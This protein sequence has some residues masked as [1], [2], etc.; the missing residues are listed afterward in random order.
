MDCRWYGR[1][2]GRKLTSERKRLIAEFLPRCRIDPAVKLDDPAVLFECS[3]RDVWMEIGFGAGEHLISQAMANPDV[4]FVGCEPYING[5]SSLLSMVNQCRIKNIRVFDNDV[6]LLMPAFPP[7]SIG[8]LYVLFSD[9]W[10]KVRHHKRRLT[11]ER[12]LDAFAR[13]LK[14]G[15]EFRFATDQ[16][17]FAVWTLERFCRD[18]RFL[19]LAHG[20]ADWQQPP[21]GWAQTRYEQKAHSRGLR[22]VYLNFRRTTE[23]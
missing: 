5:M 1:R 8:R 3:V 13:L 7:A 18:K 23:G 17:E 10:P 9:P 20:T 21:V 4:G 14:P 19:W 16:I 22:P 6:R 11:A 15:A 2:I 12:N